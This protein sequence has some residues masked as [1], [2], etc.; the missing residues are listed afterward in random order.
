TENP[1]IRWRSPSD[2]DRVA[3]GLCCHGNGIFGS[4]DVAVSY[5]GNRNRVLYSGYIFPASVAAVALFASAGVQRN[6]IEPAILGELRQFH[7]DDLRVRP[8][9]AELHRKRNPHGSAHR[10]KNSLNLRQIAQQSRA[11]IAFHYA[12]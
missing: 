3:T 11:A 5:Y 2:H 1:G 10:L 4:A 6:S 12:L 7:A 9:H 8:P